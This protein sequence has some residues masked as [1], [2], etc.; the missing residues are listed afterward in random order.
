MTRRRARHRPRA[1]PARRAGV[2]GRPAGR[3]ARPGPRRGRGRRDGRRPGRPTPSGT[4]RGRP[5]RCATRSVP[6]RWCS[7]ATPGRATC[8]RCSAPPGGPCAAPSRRTSSATPA[9]HRPARC[10]AST[11]WR[12]EDAGD[13]GRWRVHRATSPPA[14]ATRS[15]PTT[16]WPSWCPTTSVRA[17]AGRV[18]AAAGRADFFPEPLPVAPDW[19]DAP[20]GFVRLSA[21]Y[22]Q[23]ARGRAASRGWPVVPPTRRASPAGTSRR[24]SGRS[25]GRP[26]RRGARACC[27][28][29][30]RRLSRPSGGA[31][32]GSAAPCPGRCRRCDVAAAGLPAAPLLPQPCPGVGTVSV[33]GRQRSPSRSASAVSASHTWSASWPGGIHSGSSVQGSTS[34]SSSRSSATQVSVASGAGG[35]DA[36]LQP[37][38]HR[39]VAARPGRVDGAAGARARAQSSMN[40]AR[41]RASTSCMATSGSPGA[42]TSPPRAMRVSHHGR[43]PTFSCGPRI[44]PARTTSARSPNASVTARS[45]PALSTP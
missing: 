3:A 26:A 24:A 9:C 44:R 14:G 27:L 6:G 15:G 34:C 40:A 20:C 2:L 12:T 10:P 11:C 8:C 32:R 31:R 17:R 41:S 4:S 5:C 29:P 30:A 1:Q 7:S 35:G 16:T 13:D 19:P 45:Q 38:A 37:A 18:A 33:T 28:T 39:R 43:R 23:P 36:V 22:D 25:G 21:G 42:S